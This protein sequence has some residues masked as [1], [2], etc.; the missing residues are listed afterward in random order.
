LNILS[1]HLPGKLS[2]VCITYHVMK[3]FSKKFSKVLTLSSRSKTKGKQV[4]WLD[5]GP[6]HSTEFLLEQLEGPQAL[7]LTHITLEDSLQRHDNVRL[8]SALQD[9]A[10]NEASKLTQIQLLEP[11]VSASNYK[12]WSYK[13]TN[14]LHYVY[15]RCQERNIN[16]V[17]HGTLILETPEDKPQDVSSWLHHL[18]QTV[19]Q[20]PDITSLKMSLRDINSKK[21]QHKK[22]SGVILHNSLSLAVADVPKVFQAL[23]ELFNMDTRSWQS[24]HVN[25][26]YTNIPYYGASQTEAVMEVAEGYRVPV[27]IRWQPIDR[28]NIAGIW[29]RSS[30]SILAR[31]SSSSS[32]ATGKGKISIEDTTDATVT[33]TIFQGSSGALFDPNI[34]S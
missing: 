2:F 7:Q 27:Q 30:T 18:L 15:R 19:P 8:F 26:L 17:I 9:I 24:I 34:R 29:V 10:C 3:G 31:T 13:R 11:R 4:L 20:D 6:Q 22:Q 32:N 12:R 16:V 28:S 23:I 14:F 5:C 21:Y 33:S 25:V 1:T